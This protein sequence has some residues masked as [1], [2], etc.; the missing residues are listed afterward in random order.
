[1]MNRALQFVGHPL[2]LQGE[3]G[4]RHQLCRRSLKWELGKEQCG[5]WLELQGVFRGI[6]KS[7]LPGVKCLGW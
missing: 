7:G 1:M 3:G 2:S 6:E 4:V 5:L